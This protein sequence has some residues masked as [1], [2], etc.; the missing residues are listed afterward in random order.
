M[1]KFSDFFIKMAARIDLNSE[2]DF[3][4]AICIVPPEGAPI[5]S[6]VLDSNKDLSVFWGFVKARADM[7]LADIE[8]QNQQNMGYG[9]R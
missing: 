9:R 4:G 5:I 6:L 2:E 3:C 1:G 8:S 7:A